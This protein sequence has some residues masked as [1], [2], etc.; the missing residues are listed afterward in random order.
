MRS[1]QTGN[2]ALS[3]RRILSK[4]KTT[5]IEIHVI[6]S[7]YKVI[8]NGES[9]ALRRHNWLF[10]L[11]RNKNFRFVRGVIEQIRPTAHYYRKRARCIRSLKRSFKRGT[12]A[13]YSE[14][15]RQ[16][17]CYRRKLYEVVTVVEKSESVTFKRIVLRRPRKSYHSL[18]SVHVVNVR[19]VCNFFDALICIIAV[20]TESIVHIQSVSVG[21]G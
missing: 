14:K 1:D 15:A 3:Y 5:Y 12:L 4:L 2:P 18:F 20:L 11:I 21:Y 10:I 17:V 6:C 8:A 9:P 19:F 16:V 7:Y 13:A